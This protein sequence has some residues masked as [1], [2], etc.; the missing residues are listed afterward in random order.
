[1]NKYCK[2]TLDGSS[3]AVEQFSAKDVALV[4]LDSADDV[5]IVFNNGSK[6]QIAS[7][8]ALGQA[9]VSVVFGVIKNAQQ[10]RWHEVLL[11][12]P[13]LSQPVNAFTFTF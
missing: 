3:D 1:M 11:D 8:S 13:L 9:D 7:S 5:V 6:I 10:S 2:I 12:I 4:Y